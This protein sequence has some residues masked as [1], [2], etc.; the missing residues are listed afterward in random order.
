MTTGPAYNEHSLAR[1]AEILEWSTRMHEKGYVSKE[2]NDRDRRA[3]E[4]LK[5][6]IDAD[7]VRLGERVDW[8][9][10]MFEKGYVSKTQYDVEILKHYG[11][12]R[13]RQE[14]PAVNDEILEQ[15]DRLKQH[16][17]AHPAVKDPDKSKAGE[18][19]QSATSPKDASQPGK[20]GTPE[21]PATGSP[22]KGGSPPKE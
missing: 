19:P 20:A 7:I 4:S 5:S 3:Y 9:K 14:G 17:P 2:Q 16:I 8:A 11:A 21:K 12:L 15:Y 18:L 6:R 1:A 10:R 13:A 22:P